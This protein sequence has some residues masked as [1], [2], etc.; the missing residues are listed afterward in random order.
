MSV[1]SASPWRLKMKRLLALFLGLGALAA[2]ADDREP[3]AVTPEF[4]RGAP[5]AGA[6]GVTVMTRNVYLGADLDPIIAAGTEEE[7]FVAVA[8]AWAT[9]QLTN[10]PARAEALA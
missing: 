8:T 2:C 9:L 5:A 1:Y 3:L 4:A 10:F 7:F 6:R